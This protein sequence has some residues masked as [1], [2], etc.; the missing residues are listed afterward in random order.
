MRLGTLV[1]ALC[2]AGSAQA[3]SSV[4]IYTEVSG[5]QL[6][7]A[8]DSATFSLDR[9]EAGFR[10]VPVDSTQEDAALGLR[11]GR[12]L[13]A[14]TLARPDSERFLAGVRAAVAGR[15][16]PY[17]MLEASRAQ[18]LMQDSIRTRLL[19]QQART[20]PGARD[21]LARVTAGREASA[22]FLDAAMAEPGAR[23]T[24]S[25]IVYRVV[26]P[27]R[28]ASPSFE[29]GVRVTYAGRLPD[30]SEFDRSPEGETASFGVSGV[31]VGFGE[32]LMDMAP[33]ERRVI[34]IP[35]PLAYGV[36]GRGPIPPA[37]AIQFDL[38]LVEVLAAPPP[39]APRSR[40]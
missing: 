4:Q 39:P 24:A 14:D 20:A 27:G 28:G 30:G 31:V 36:Q 26:E 2:L 23:R 25:G 3:Q 21:F 8:Q 11:V 13:R 12:V 32:M 38:T 16:M 1:L 22:A 15:P 35:A 29:N 6:G 40:R 17:S 9:F 18:A 33:G 37:T 10:G 19:E 5:Y 34:T 7:A